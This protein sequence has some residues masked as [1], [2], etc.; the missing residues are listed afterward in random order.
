MPVRCCCLSSHCGVFLEWEGQGINRP[1]PF[2]N[3]GSQKAK[4]QWSAG[5]YG[6]S[7]VLRC[8]PVPAAQVD[9]STAPA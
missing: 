7:V 8:I 2:G 4:D 5:R 1:S 6:G 3:S 9:I